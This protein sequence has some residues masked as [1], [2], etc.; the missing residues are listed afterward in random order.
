MQEEAGLRGAKTSAFGVD[1]DLAI[2]V[3]VTLTGDTPEA[4][5]MAVKL[6]EG[7]AIKVKDNSVI[8]HPT[9]KLTKTGNKVTV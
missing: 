4:H 1:P 3:D 7:P 5:K 6:G 8:S 9:Q 2:A